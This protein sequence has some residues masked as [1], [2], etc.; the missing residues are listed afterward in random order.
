M[1]TEFCITIL[2]LDLLFFR[3]Y[4]QFQA[5]G[6]VGVVLDVIKPYV[7]DYSLRVLAPE[8]IASSSVTARPVLM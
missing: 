8:L 5:A 4:K 1:C 6:Y 7:L 2:R 3:L